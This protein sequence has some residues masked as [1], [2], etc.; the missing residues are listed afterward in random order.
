MGISTAC[1]SAVIEVSHHA[2][3]TI[4]AEVYMISEQEWTYELQHLCDDV[5]GPGGHNRVADKNKEAG[6]AWAKVSNHAVMLYQSLNNTLAPT[7]CNQYIP[8]LRKWRSSHL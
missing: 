1:T 7:R 2:Q 3:S 4:K 5:I 6:I 8:I